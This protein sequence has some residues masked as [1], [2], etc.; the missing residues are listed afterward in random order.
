MNSQ[1]TVDPPLQET[2]G[3]AAYRRIREDIV[4][5]RL[6]PGEKLRLERMKVG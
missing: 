6:A 1:I 2:A 3:E 4:F 5:G